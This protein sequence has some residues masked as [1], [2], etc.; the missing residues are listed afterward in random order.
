MRAT[1]PTGVR[2]V[3]RHKLIHLGLTPTLGL[4][5][6]G[7]PSALAADGAPA[8]GDTSEVLEEVVVTAQFRETKL[9]DTPIAI[10]A[11]T[12]NMLEA[13]S[14]TDITQVANQAPNVTLTPT[15]SAFGPGVTAYIRG[16]GQNDTSFALEPGVGMYIDDVYYSTVLGSDFDLLDLDRV[17]ILR[18]P[19]GTLAGM[20]SIGGAVRLYSK[21]PGED[22]DGFLEG[23]VGSF[24]RHDFRGAANFSLITDHLFVRLTG[25]AKSR[26]GYVDRVDYACAHPGSDVPSAVVNAGSNCKLGTYGGQNTQ[27]MRAQLRWLAMEGLEINL[28]GDITDDRSDLVPNVLRGL[29]PGGYTFPNG[30]PVDS[31]FMPSASHPYLSYAT[32]CASPGANALEHQTF[33]V[34]ANNSLTSK[35]ASLDVT[36]N[37]AGNL[38]AKSISAY[39]E[40][41]N[42]FGADADETPYDYQTLYNHF[43]H[44]QFSQELRLSG[45]ALGNAIDWTT[46]GFYF[47]ST[48][49]IGGRIDI[50]GTFDFTPHD[51]VVLQ[52]ESGFVH[53]VWHATQR[54]N[55]T[56]G[57]RYTHESK[58]YTFYRREATNQALVP[59]SLVGIDGLH[60][61][62]E[63]SHSDYKVSLDYH[64]TPAVMGYL[65]WSTGFRGGGVAPRPFFANQGVSFKPETLDAYEVGLKSDLF[66]RSL[67][68]NLSAFVNNYKNIVLSPLSAFFNP[69]LPVDNNPAD[70]LY[71]PNTP[72]F[73]GTFPSAVPQNAGTARFKGVELEMQWHPA[74]G[75]SMDLSGSWIQFNYTHLA[76]GVVAVA[77]GG[78]CISGCLTLNAPWSYTPK[79]KASAGA[80]YELRLA[81]GAALTPRVDVNSQS[82]FFT[83]VPVTDLGTVAAYTVANARLMWRSASATWDAA[84]E[85]TNLGNRIYY[86]NA[87]DFRSIGGAASG[88]I[89]PPREWGLSLRHNF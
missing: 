44:Y 53:A 49:I 47:H 7:P 21:K 75:F 23:T 32:Y 40:Y 8:V 20:N 39:R 88:V 78:T 86:T 60:S 24:N 66:D 63:G 73:F 59:P 45:T 71:N 17:E 1:V 54:I 25:L 35:G 26:N 4:V 13:R 31:S 89:A 85:V 15:A 62:Y 42:G 68:V 84:L 22:T 51:P 19:Q 58:D 33:C 38:T 48:S 6:C 2:N 37:G 12:A 46:G 61:K 72:P 18:G 16:I 55:L 81:N 65:Q 3:L 30:T 28:I 80:Q 5:L 82:R 76:P 79:W 70:I 34:P 36:W 69:N 41:D 50:P 52:N 83:S 67:R 57:Y 9:Q 27:A 64:F 74:R 11:V 14:Q 43:T 77:Q 29:P 10:T 87:I 56:A